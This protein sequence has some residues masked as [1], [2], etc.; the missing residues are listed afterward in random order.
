MPLRLFAVFL[1]IIFLQIFFFNALTLFDL[2]YAFVFI[3]VLLLLPLDWDYKWVIS[4][5]FVVGIIM[6]ISVL[7]L[8]I[9]AFTSVLMVTLR[10]SWIYIITPQINPNDKIDFKPFSQSFGWSLAYFTP[11]IFFYSLIYHLLADLQFTLNTFWKFFATGF[12]TSTLVLLIYT[13][14]IKTSEKR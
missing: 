4:L 14:F 9:H 3:I 1:M 2:A 8:G 6:D 10:N 13:L 12:Y 11:L 7:K 5:A